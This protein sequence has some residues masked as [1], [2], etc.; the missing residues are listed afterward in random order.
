M[1]EFDLIMQAATARKQTGLTACK[2]YR[3]WGVTDGRFVTPGN[4][5]SR[6]VKPS[7][8]NFFPLFQAERGCVEDQPKQVETLIAFGLLRLV[9]PDTAAL[10]LQSWR[11]F[12]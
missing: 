1:C 8:G 12:G 3:D 11:V 7:H 5:Q 9:L 2:S 4:T 6:S 10:L